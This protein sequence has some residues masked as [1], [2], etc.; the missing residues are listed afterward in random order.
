MI[1]FIDRFHLPKLNEDQVNYLNIP[2]SPKLIATVIKSSIPPH[3]PKRSQGHMVL[4][5]FHQTFKEPL[6]AVLLKSFH[7]I[8]TLTKTFCEAELLQLRTHLSK[9]LNTILSQ[10]HQYPSFIQKITD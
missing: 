4:T 9:W 8:E 7:K 1:V 10:K 6:I 2:R 3:P 5:E